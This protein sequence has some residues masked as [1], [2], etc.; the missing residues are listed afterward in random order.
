MQHPGSRE[1]SVRMGGE[2]GVVVV[3]VRVLRSAVPRG[4]AVEGPPDFRGGVG[5]D[6]LEEGAEETGAE[7]M[8]EVRSSCPE[9]VQDKAGG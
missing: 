3:V 5:E 1:R 6:R 4:M 2:G 7:E 9:R 8:T